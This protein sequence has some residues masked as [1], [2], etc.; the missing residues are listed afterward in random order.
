MTTVGGV[1]REFHG[2]TNKPL[3][4]MP[5]GEKAVGG[6][7]INCNGVS[8]KT[9]S[10]DPCGSC[11]C[12]LRLHLSVCCFRMHW[13]LHLLLASATF[14]QWSRGFCYAVMLTMPVVLL[15]AAACW[16]ACF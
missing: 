5:K 12:W 8:T 2:F 6:A 14:F 16:S 3:S 15:A 11:A 7:T 13:W 4:Q 10:L 1:D 9:F